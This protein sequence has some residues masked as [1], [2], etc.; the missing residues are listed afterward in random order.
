MAPLLRSRPGASRT[1]G[2][3]TGEARAGGGA[4]G[5]RL[6]RATT[7]SP[8][9]AARRRPG[10][11]L[12]GLGLVVAC[13]AA[14]AELGKA[15]GRRSSYLEL[16]RTVPVGA[17]I[18]ARDLSILS[19]SKPAG[20]AVVPGRASG[21]VVGHLAA[22]T[23]PAGSLLV[24][25]DVAHGPALGAGKAL[26]GTS[27]AAD[28]A[29]GGLA[30]G[31]TV[32]ALLTGPNGGSPAE[33]GGAAARLAGPWLATGT[34]LGVKGRSSGQREVTVMVPAGAAGALAAASAAG[35]LCLVELPRAAAGTR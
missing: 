5:G 19:M 1:P 3:A 27:L 7:A 22:A 29:P 18:E 20:V 9:P 26:V 15:P 31:D 4:L 25:Q 14:G 24:Y 23:L 17:T 16:S 30:P 34:V 13:A 2:G 33:G 11:A 10:L 32:R 21:S 35:E 28:Q 6:R 12:V 8:G